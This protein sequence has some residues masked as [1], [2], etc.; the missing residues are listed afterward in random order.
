MEFNKFKVNLEVLKE[1]E[2]TNDSIKKAIEQQ[3]ELLRKGVLTI[4]GI[5]YKILESTIT[6]KRSDLLMMIV[7]LDASNLK[8]EV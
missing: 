1:I 6:E 4:N 7:E 2:N 8:V 5:E 3:A